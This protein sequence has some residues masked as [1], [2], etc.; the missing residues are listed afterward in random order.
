MKR[1]LYWW[2]A[3]ASLAAAGLAFGVIAVAGPGLPPA[4]AAVAHQ[5]QQ[6]CTRAYGMCQV[7][8]FIHVRRDGTEWI[9]TCFAQSPV[10]PGA[11]NIWIAIVRCIRP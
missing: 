6:Q 11:S 1:I 8:E 7:T 9:E 5:A 2:P 10:K 3:L 4:R